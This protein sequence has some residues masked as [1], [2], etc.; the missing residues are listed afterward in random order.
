MRAEDLRE[1]G[2]GLLCGHGPVWVNKYLGHPRVKKEWHVHPCQR[3]AHMPP[4]GTVGGLAVPKA[5]DAG[6]PKVILLSCSCYDP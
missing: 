6:C 1:Q 3:E 5:E 2:A 4:P